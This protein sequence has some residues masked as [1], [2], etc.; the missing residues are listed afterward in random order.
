MRRRFRARGRISLVGT[1]LMVGGSAVLAGCLPPPPPPPPPATLVVSPPPGT[2]QP[3]V[4]DSTLH[5][6]DVRAIT[7]TN[8]GGVKSSAIKI[9]PNTSTMR[10]TWTL[11]TD[12]CSGVALAAGAKCGFTIR[13]TSTRLSG[14]SDSFYYRVTGGAQDTYLYVAGTASPTITVLVAGFA[15]PGPVTVIEDSASVPGY[16]SQYFAF[17][18]TTSN[19]IP[20]LTT[21]L[22]SSTGSGVFTSVPY[23]SDCKQ[24]LPPSG[25]CYV[26]V[27]Y[28]NAGTG[29]GNVTVKLAWADGDVSIPILG[30]PTP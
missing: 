15:P 12:T 28:E 26:E 20:P 6:S 7:L 1:A 16:G 23:V 5:T 21:S 14:F 22:N 4:S 8:V 13:F 18:N 3:F 2:I 27:R 10:G 24:S 30:R 17:T 11:E 19:W 29:E 9:A 25:T